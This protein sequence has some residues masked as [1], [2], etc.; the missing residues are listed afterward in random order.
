[1]GVIIIQ[2][3][4]FQQPI[5]NK[6]AMVTGCLHFPASSRVIALLKVNDATDTIEHVEA[7]MGTLVCTALL[8]NYMNHKA[9]ESCSIVVPVIP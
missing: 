5:A 9:Q 7:A 2:Y 3:L 6:R 1:M 4:P 8:A